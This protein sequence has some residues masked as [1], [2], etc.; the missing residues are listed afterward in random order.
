MGSISGSGSTRGGGN[1]SPL[2]Y[3]CLGNP[4][5]RGTWWIPVHGVKGVR[6]L[7]YETTTN[8]VNDSTVVS[9]S[10]CNWK[11]SLNYNNF[12]LIS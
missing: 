10:H 11:S 12:F 6:Q 3:S 1:G 5:N 4:T 8:Y 7:S 9:G 2:Q